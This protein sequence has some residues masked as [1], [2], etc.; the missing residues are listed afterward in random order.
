MTTGYFVNHTHWD[1]EW[2][3]TEQD[4]I[5]LSDSLFSEVIT[6]LENHPDANFTLDGQTS[7]VNEYSEMHPEDKVRIRKLVA[8]K[9]LFIGP[10]YTQ[11]DAMLPTGESIIRNL[12]IGIKDSRENYGTPMMIG[13]LPDTFGFNAQLPMLL[14]QVGIKDF[15]FWRGI[16]F[17][18]HVNSPY[19]TWKSLGNNK[20]TAANFPL[21]YYTGQITV[22]SKKNLKEFVENRLDPG[23]E[24]ESENGNNLDVLIPSGIDQMNI[25]HKESET[26]SDV[27]SYSKYNLKISSYPE[28]MEILHKKKQLP[29]Y[30]GE[31]RMPA[32]ARVHRTIGSVRS[33]IKRN[34]FYL[35]QKILKV[36]EPLSI[37]ARQAGINIS[38]GLLL[39]LWKKLLEVHPHDSLGGSVSDNVS[40]DIDHRFKEGFE[41]A[42]GIENV[43]KKRIAQKLKLSDNDVLVFNTS[44]KPF[45]GFKEVSIISPTDK[46]KFDD[47]Y[48]ATVINKSFVAE[49]HNIMMQTEKGF[50]FKDEPSYYV[51]KILIKLD[52]D[53]LGYQ[54]ISFNESE[55]LTNSLSVVN[56]TTIKN[57]LWKIT[58]QDGNILIA[59]K[60]QTYA[61][62]LRIFDSGNDG[63]TYD[64]SPIA[65]ELEKELPI[66]GQVTTKHSNVVSYITIKGQ[67]SLPSSL[68][69][70]KKEN[71]DLTTV[72]YIFTIKLVK[73]DPVISVELKINN[74]VKDHR[75]R[76][77]LE[78]DNK[79]GYALAK[80][81]SGFIKQKNNPISD[82]WEDKF[83]E[84]PV[85]IYNFED[86][87]GIPN[88]DQ[89]LF[90]ISKGMKEY[91]L[92]ED[93]IFI[94]LMA[95]T[96]QLG[97]PNLMWRPGRASGDT[98]SIGH[99]M[100]P[101]PL[102]EELG[103]NL[104]EFG[105]FEQ[106]NTENYNLTVE[107]SDNWLNPN[108]GYQMQKLDLFKNRLDNKLWK[109]EEESHVDI[110][111]NFVSLNTPLQVIASYPALNIDG[112]YVIRLAN[113]S[114]NNIDVSSI[115][116]EG[117]TITNALEEVIDVNDNIV[118]PYDV[119]TMIKKYK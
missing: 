93:G 8:R 26:L 65:G 4:A 14:N 11:T 116:A 113:N 118:E 5:V 78:S 53:G 84:K 13:Y 12:V 3:F 43:I 35:E 67:W 30:Q 69:E 36:V 103:D 58:Y 54:I 57:D 110:E 49:R 19:F 104:F 61:K 96:G 7:I 71:P 79:I 47:K 15:I 75:L 23:I 44:L 85:N 27:S 25:I 21:G 91:E 45:H 22:D 95:T 59:S 29:E 32:Y 40:E 39:K 73:D 102:A 24:F 80:L 98:T 89:N 1:R 60:D 107:V 82:D 31:F 10:W 70:R 109:T 52:F 55:Y 81:S 42:D 74:T 86:I 33:H 34:N 16:D 97:K 64:Y 56:A 119:I 48:Q 37:I 90:L 46:I 76:V 94:T 50:E 77:K 28:F 20:V 66:N 51:L 117:Y 17:N 83:V 2:Y 18:Y 111:P 108:I 68:I 72:P 100:M 112:F 115:V 92:A 41:I 6:E 87:V 101:T 106:S 114:G 105:I 63:D 88:Q 38:N 99:K 9:Q 62:I